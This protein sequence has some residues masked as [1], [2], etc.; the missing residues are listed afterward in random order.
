MDTAVKFYF[1]K[2]KIILYVSKR[3]YY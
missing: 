1:K 2:G 3:L